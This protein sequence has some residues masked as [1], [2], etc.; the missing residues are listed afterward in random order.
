MQHRGAVGVI[1]QYRDFQIPVSFLSV[2]YFSH[3]HASP[4][5]TANYPLSHSIC[6]E[7][8]EHQGFRI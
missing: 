1:H 2:R 8:D 6:S 7:R 3:F 4:N 5:Y